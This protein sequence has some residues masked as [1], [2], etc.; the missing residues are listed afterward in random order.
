MR[1]P[2]RLF[3]LLAALLSAGLAPA[4]T[5]KIATIVPDGTTWMQEMRATGQRIAERTDGRVTL[6]FYPGGVM[7]NAGTVLRKMRVGQLHG[8]AFTSTELGAIYPDYL[9]YG[10]P[11]LFD[12][13]EEI[14]AVRS[15]MDETLAEGLRERGLVMLGMAGGGFGYLMS[16]R[17]IGDRE[18]LVDAKVW[19]PAG[20]DV[21][22]LALEL[23]GV[24]PIPLPLSDV[25]TGLQ[26]GL[27]DTVVNTPVG[28]IAFQWHTKLTHFTDLPVT[29]VA[30]GVAID[31]RTFDRLSET[32]QAVLREEMAATLA[33][34]QEQDIADNRDARAA[35]KNEGIEPVTLSEEDVGYWRTL[36]GRTLEA[37]EAQADGRYEH[38][39]LLEATL[40][41]VRA[42]A[43]EGAGG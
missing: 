1:P 19:V 21:S 36:A 24:S 14:L 25:Y 41:A 23:A 31:A 29:Y 16:D 4:A 30:G 43:G 28:A 33:T 2:L 3:T 10:I 38:I 17:P 8:G 7:G 18:A 11:F 42:E 34:L 32:D 9:L 27:I 39:E 20:D 15:R 22:A 6:K 40:T 26:T 35:L 37:L 5:L 12:D 13:L